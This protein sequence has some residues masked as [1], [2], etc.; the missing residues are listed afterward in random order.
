M[1][2]NLMRSTVLKCMKQYWVYILASHKRTLYVGMTNNLERRIY[3]HRHK[4]IEGFTKRYNVNQTG[5]LRRNQRCEC[6]YRTRKTHQ[7]LD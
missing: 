5:L 4:L 2:K 3:E 7:R 6:G 1:A